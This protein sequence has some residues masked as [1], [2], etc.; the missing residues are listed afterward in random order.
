MPAQAAEGPQRLAHVCQG[1]GRWCC[2]LGR[3]DSLQPVDA[4]VGLRPQN[5]GTK[6]DRSH[7]AACQATAERAGRAARR[8]AWESSAGVN[9][10]VVGAMASRTGKLGLAQRR[11]RRAH[12]ADVIKGGLLRRGGLCRA[13]LWES[14]SY[15]RSGNGEMGERLLATSSVALLFVSS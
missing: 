2:P 1:W 6:L 15:G 4:P 8:R 13:R 3:K 5:G 14:M 12:K 10:R 7:R 9:E 11:A